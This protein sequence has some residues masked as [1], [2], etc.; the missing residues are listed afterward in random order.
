[1]IMPTRI[2]DCLNYLVKHHPAYRNIKI[3]TKED[4]MKQCPG[5]FEDAESEDNEVD[6]SD[7][8]DDDLSNNDENEKKN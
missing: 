6:D 2:Y 3:L 7:S 4:W 1:M 5:F 8:D